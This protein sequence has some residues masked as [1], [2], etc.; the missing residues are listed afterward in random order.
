MLKGGNQAWGLTILRVVVGVVFLIHGWQK[1][2]IYGFHGVTTSFAHMGVPAPAVSA[3]LITLVELIGGAAL[4]LG[5]GTHIAGLLLA[6]DMAGAI[7]LVHLKNGFFG[8]KGYEYPLTLLAACLC[9]VLAGA[10]ASSVEGIVRG[11]KRG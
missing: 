1:A 9:M 11:R 2:F 7:I 10:G 6:A 8:P 3:P 5:I 4:I